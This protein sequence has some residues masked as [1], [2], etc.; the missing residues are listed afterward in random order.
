MKKLFI[1]LLIITSLSIKAQ[2]CETMIISEGYSMP[3]YDTTM[4]GDLI[5]YYPSQLYN[6]D[7]DEVILLMSI[8]I[9]FNYIEECE[10]D[11]TMYIRHGGIGVSYLT[12]PE[13]LTWSINDTIWFHGKEPTLKGFAEWI[14]KTYKIEKQ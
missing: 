5:G 12:F 2:D 11:S 1:L 6:A 7:Q 10:K 13:H 8:S 3:V 14:M 4:P 9:L